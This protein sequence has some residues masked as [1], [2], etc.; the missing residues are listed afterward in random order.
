MN[1][2]DI[3]TI[4]DD[5]AERVGPLGSAAWDILV[6][7]T[8]AVS[9]IG[10]I[11]GLALLTLGPIVAVRMY[12]KARSMPLNHYNSR[13]DGSVFLEAVAWV[14]G[15]IGVIF[16]TLKAAHNAVGVFAPEFRVLEQ[17]ISTLRGG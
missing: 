8:W 7:G 17:M 4:L 5:I 10:M 14:I 1:P 16:G 2:E 13:T 11:V 3:A 6:H 9:L 15:V 12:N